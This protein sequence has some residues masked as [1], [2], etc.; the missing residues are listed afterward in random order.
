M[1]KKPRWRIALTIL[2][3]LVAFGL[4]SGY[5][6]TRIPA[7]Q[8]ALIL[9]E[10]RSLMIGYNPSE[11]YGGWGWA[12]RAQLQEE[13]S[14]ERLLGH[15]QVVQHRIRQMVF[16]G[17]QSL[18]EYPGEW[19]LMVAGLRMQ[20][21]TNPE[22]L[23]S[24]FGLTLMA[25]TLVAEAS[26]PPWWFH[27]PWLAEAS[28]AKPENSF[29]LGLLTP[30]DI[31][32]ILNRLKECD[33]RQTAALVAAVLKHESA[34]S[35]EQRTSILDH[36]LEVQQ[37][38]K[39]VNKNNVPSLV[40]ALAFRRK[41]GELLARTGEPS[42]DVSLKFDFTTHLSGRQRREI[43]TTLMDFVR[44]LGYRP[45]EANGK[46][47]LHIS[48]AYTSVAF[49]DVA[50]QYRE[51][52]S[53]TKRVPKQTQSRYGASTLYREETSTQTHLIGQVEDSTMPT[54]VL[55]A[56]VQ[57]EVMEIAL[58]PFGEVEQDTRD[59]VAPLMTKLNLSGRELF[60]WN[61]CLEEYA[62][63]PWRFGLDLY[64]DW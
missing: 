59:R 60:T 34:F 4:W 26:P 52:R 9:K 46:A 42:R 23:A 54:L 16:R 39:G 6:V 12:E 21:K 61:W 8:R 3:A 53:T 49:G 22:I 18:Y 28:N 33:K 43:A 25:A 36:W 62:L 29:H 19:A 35:P 1:R 37:K 40:Q 47:E 57:S 56:T 32:P 7:V 51:Q 64:R 48:V 13:D 41:L 14:G 30:S 11:F 17:G 58:R 50:V 24:E 45:H 10:H 38:G 20:G 27:E 2:G 55:K 5:L 63:R 31:P 44:S 15:E